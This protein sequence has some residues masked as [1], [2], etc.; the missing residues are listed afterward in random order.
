MGVGCQ[1]YL[2]SQTND[3]FGSSSNFLQLTLRERGQIRGKLVSLI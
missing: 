3:L 1:G 2:F